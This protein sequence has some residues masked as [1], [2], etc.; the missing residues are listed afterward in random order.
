MLDGKFLMWSCQYFSS[1]VMEYLM[2]TTLFG[3][4]E[5]YFWKYYGVL[6]VYYMCGSF[7]KEW[8]ENLPDV[9]LFLSQHLSQFLWL[10]FL[11][12]CRADIVGWKIHV[13]NV[14]CL[15]VFICGRGV[16]GRNLD[17]RKCILV[18]ISTMS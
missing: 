18:E 14:R 2:P 9:T 15:C 1:F 16:C 8:L 17:E 6:Y 5:M 10:V 4:N 7:Q 12:C 13:T 11:L 3:K